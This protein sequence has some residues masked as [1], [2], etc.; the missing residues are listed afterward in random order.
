M[1][2]RRHRLMDKMR[3]CAQPRH[4]PTMAHQIS[5]RSGGS[6][7]MVVPQFCITLASHPHIHA[8]LLKPRHPSSPFR[9]HSG[10]DIPLSLIVK[11]EQAR[12][13]GRQRRTKNKAQ[14]NQQDKMHPAHGHENTASNNGTTSHFGLVF[15]FTRCQKNLCQ[16]VTEQTKLDGGCH[17]LVQNAV[18][19]FSDGDVDVELLIQG[20]NAL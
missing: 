14:P 11:P 18:Y 9:P 8:V 2:R 20:V 16:L 5:I 10:R 13:L 4:T 19:R 1:T 12:I 6:L 7:N 17:F 3:R 15:P